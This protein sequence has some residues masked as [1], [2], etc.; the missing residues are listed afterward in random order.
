MKYKINVG[1]ESGDGHSQ[2]EIIYFEANKT[3]KEMYAAYT[4]AVKKS[5]V[6][7]HSNSGKI[8]L[9]TDYSDYDFPIH[10]YE[11]L[12][13]AGVNVSDFYDDGNDEAFLPDHHNSLVILLLEMVKSQLPDLEY[14]IIEDDTEIFDVGGIGY[15]LFN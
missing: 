5:G 13:D 10:A 6:A 11:A 14:E 3:L 12:K 8:E 1:D 9:F 2:Y 15:G 7:L 4:K